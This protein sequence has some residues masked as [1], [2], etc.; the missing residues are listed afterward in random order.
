MFGGPQA[1]TDHVE[2][3]TYTWNVL[4]AGLRPTG[5][6]G[7]AAGIAAELEWTYGELIRLG[8]SETHA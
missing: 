8:L 3:E 7:V 4:P 2:V 5:S 1:I 6:A